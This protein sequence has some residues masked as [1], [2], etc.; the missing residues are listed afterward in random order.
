MTEKLVSE[1][2]WKDA[3]AGVPAFSLPLGPVVVLAPHPD[4]ECLAAGGFIAALAH[5]GTPL[6]VVAIT[7]GDAAYDPA[8][9]LK[10]A[11][12]RR[13]EQISALSILGLGEDQIVRFNL[14]D[15]WVHEHE[16]DLTE[17]LS[18]L[19][20]STGPTT[21]LIAPWRCDFHSDHEAVGRAAE[22][23]TKLTGATLV[24]WFWWSWHHRTVAELS[25]LPLKRFPLEAR[26]LQ[27]KLAGIAEHRSQLG[28]DAILSESLLAPAQRDFEVFA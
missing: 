25:A 17:R 15:R 3:L 8:G 21:T 14:P 19:L 10:L 18:T 13:R 28:E 22:C 27:L 1:A 7:D 5:H 20:A 26:W 9:D 2:D 4:D 12:R 11:E 23:A 24:R 16:G 6:T